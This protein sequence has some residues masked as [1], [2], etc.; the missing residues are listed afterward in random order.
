VATERGAAI[1]PAAATMVGI[2]VDVARAEH[3]DAD[4]P[5]PR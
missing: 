3:A 5:A 2:L 4:S 1:A